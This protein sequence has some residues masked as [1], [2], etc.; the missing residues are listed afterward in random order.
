MYQVIKG[1]PDECAL[2]V[3]YPA[4]A[5]FDKFD[6]VIVSINATGK[7][8]LANKNGTADTFC[9]GFLIGREYVSRKCTVLLG[10]SVIECDSD[11]FDATKTYTAGTKL[12]VLSG[13][14]TVGDSNAEVVGR[15]VSYDSV[16]QKLVILC[17][18]Y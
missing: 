7:V 1:W 18:F 17:R 8:D 16:A 9:K 2:D 13:K 15:V 6:G 10:D 11:H 4:A 5:D 12:T 3:A 14:F